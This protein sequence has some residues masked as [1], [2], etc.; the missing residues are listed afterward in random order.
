MKEE[1][2]NNKI[3]YGS[4]IIA[5]IIILS[6][7]VSYAWF[8]SKI[9]K[10][11]NLVTTGTLQI[12][13]DQGNYIDASNIKPAT[14]AQVLESYKNGSCIYKQDREQ[15]ITNEHIC[16]YNTF[17]ITNTGS[18]NTN[19]FIDL[20]DVT[21]TYTSSYL[22][23]K[24]L[25]NE[26][27][28][29][30]GYVLNQTR[31][32]SNVELQTS[33]SKT[34]TL[35]VWLD[36]N[37][38]NPD[39]EKEYR[40][41]INVFGRETSYVTPEEYFSL[42][43]NIDIST[44]NIVD[45]N[46]CANFIFNLFKNHNNIEDS[47]NYCSDIGDSNG[48]TF[49]NDIKDAQDSGEYFPAGLVQEMIN[50][51]IINCSYEPIISHFYN[52]D[53]YEEYGKEIDVVIPKQFI[54]Y[55][56]EV[57]ENPTIEDI[58]NCI[59]SMKGDDYSEQDAITICNGGEVSGTSLE[60]LRLE[61]Y[62]MPLKMIE[63]EYSMYKFVPAITKKIKV[64]KLTN[65]FT[66]GNIKSIIIPEGVTE[67]GSYAFSQNQL[68]DIVLPSTLQKI[69]ERAFYDNYIN[70]IIIPDNVELIG[71]YAFAFNNIT[72][73]EMGN[74]IKKIGKWSFASNTI[75]NL[76][77]KESKN[78]TTID[79]YAFIYNEIPFLSIPDSIVSIG[80]QAFSFNALNTIYIGTKSKLIE[81]DGISGGAFP[82]SIDKS[83]YASSYMTGDSKNLPTAYY[84]NIELSTVYNNSGKVFD[85]KNI[86]GSYIYNGNGITGVVK[87]SDNR[88][89]NIITGE[90]P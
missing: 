85:W 2:K 76:N 50:K 42:N 26:P 23:Y 36:E 22:R 77:L 31:L 30:V 32:A 83:L 86:F 63:K 21:N 53:F 54:I 51:N 13:Y 71:E 80:E 87:K 84:N 90:N 55:T 11:S 52:G 47:K 48:N 62:Y 16:A 46:K 40:A 41:K 37:A 12:K 82:S 15:G 6:I 29:L 61:L 17:T 39:M 59:T 57:K 1:R 60:T 66:H 44:L 49:K 27:Q 75:S 25:E 70:E 3:Y 78:D 18:I 65:M 4:I 28:E 24:L 19:V 58:N 72:R 35:L 79:E 73:V 74:S 5:I 67:I 43:A 69:G 10:N 88:Q 45:N 64:T 68:T 56:L 33:K 8:T 38:K 9:V 81:N 20:I 14:E 7:G 34:F 89:I